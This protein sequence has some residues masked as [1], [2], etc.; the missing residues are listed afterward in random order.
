MNSG[1]RKM[2]GNAWLAEDLLAFQEELCCMDSVNKNIPHLIALPSRYIC[3][4][5]RPHRLYEAFIIWWDKMFYYLLISVASVTSRSQWPRGLRRGSAAARLL[6]LSVR[7][8]PEAWMSV[9]FNCCVLS[10]RDLCVGL[11]SRPEES[12]RVLCVWVWSL[13]LDNVGALTH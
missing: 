11:I 1:L 13:S 12:D 3:T 10:G 9:S 8:P 6:G 4:F 5:L 2:R 7:I